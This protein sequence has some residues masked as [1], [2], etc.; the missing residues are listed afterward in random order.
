MKSHIHIEKQAP[1]E[2]PKGVWVL[3]AGGMAKKQTGGTWISFQNNRQLQ[4]EP[5]WWAHVPTEN[6]I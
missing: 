4:W 5:K 2:A 6:N 1:D 3:V